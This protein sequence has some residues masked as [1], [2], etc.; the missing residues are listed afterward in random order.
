MSKLP[1]IYVRSGVHR[2]VDVNAP[3][4]CFVRVCVCV[5]DLRMLRRYA[6]ERERERER[7]GECAWFN[8]CRWWRESV[9][10][11]KKYT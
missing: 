2:N 5:V 1:F 7:E 10:K 9:L 3:F 4:H 6:R 11:T 8:Q